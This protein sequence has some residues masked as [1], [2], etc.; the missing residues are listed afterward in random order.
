[1][2]RSLQMLKL[3]YKA[4]LFIFYLAASSYSQSNTLTAD[5]KYKFGK[6]KYDVYNKVIVAKNGNIV[7]TG[8]SDWVRFDGYSSL[9]VPKFCTKS[10]DNFCYVN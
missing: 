10:C 6:T 5:W 4:I 1:M 2:G 8:A 9:L 3:N 7:A